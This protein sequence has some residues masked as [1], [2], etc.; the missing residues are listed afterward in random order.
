[1]A[2]A[3]PEMIDAVFDVRGDTLP[4]TYP[5]ALWRAL[6]RH[7]PA[8]EA[9][10]AVG[11]VPLRI[12]ASETGMLLPKR[13]KLALRLPPALAEHAAVLVGQQLDIEGSVLHLGSLKLR[14]LQS[15]PTLHAHLVSSD[16]DEVQFL[17]EVTARLAELDI[18]AKLICG[19]RNTLH[20]P[21]RVIC[22]Y[23]LVIHDLK[24]EA[25]L[26]LQ[27]TGLGADRRYGCGIFVPYKAITDLD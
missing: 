3:V 20:T 25:S 9:D 12:T 16:H 1:M 21:E 27:Y 4:V 13:A 7:M 8:A 11:V 2:E 23:S 14:P 17:Q 5:F 6:L 19:M 15:Y 26:R 18:A 24:P 22:G 10:A